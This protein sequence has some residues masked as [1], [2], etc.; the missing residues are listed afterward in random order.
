MTDSDGNVAEICFNAHIG[1]VVDLAPE[2]LVTFYPAYLNLMRMIRDPAYAV[3]LRL[4]AGEMVV[5]DNRRV[6]HGRGAFDPNTGLRHLHGCYVDRG[7]FDSRLR[8][9][10]KA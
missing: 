6:L 9:M 10:Q 7:D 3:R 5:F 1:D 4:E 2:D 8:M